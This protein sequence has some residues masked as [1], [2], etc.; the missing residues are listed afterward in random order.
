MGWTEISGDY[1]VIRRHVSHVVEGLDDFER[2]V[3]RPGGFMLPRGPHGGRIYHTVT[4]MA[5]FT[6][7][8]PDAPDVPEGYLLLQTMRSHDQFNTTVYGLDDRSRGIRG[9]V[10]WRSSMRTIFQFAVSPTAT[11]LTS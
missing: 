5:R 3:E 2:R 4:G 1:T 9:G 7:N 6:R 10:R 11:G 8:P